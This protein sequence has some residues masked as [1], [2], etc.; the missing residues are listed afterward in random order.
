MSVQVSQLR[1]VTL[2][3]LAMLLMFISVEINGQSLEWVKQFEA[4]QSFCTDMIVDN[5]LNV[6]TSG[7]FADSI[8]LN[9]GPAKAMRYAQS[10][11][12]INHTSF[13]S[14]LDAQGNFLWGLAYQTPQV[15][16][17]ISIDVDQQNNILVVGQFAD[18]IDLD[19]GPNSQWAYAKG[20]SLGTFR[21]VFIAKYDSLGNYIWGKV[22]SAP[23]TQNSHVVWADQIKVDP[24]NNIIVSGSFKDTV[25]FDP[26]LAVF[27]M[28]GN[29]ASTGLAG[30]KYLLKLDVN[31]NFVWA[32]KWQSSLA[33]NDSGY[34]GAHEIDI[35]ATGNIVMPINFLGSIDI[36]PNSA[37]NTVTSN[38]NVDFSILKISPSGS[39]IWHKEFG[40][41][42]GN[43]CWGLSLDTWGNVIIPFESYGFSLDVD[44]G[45]AI[46]LLSW[47]NATFGRIIVK[48][49]ANG[50][51]VWGFRN[52]ENN[53]F[54][55]GWREA[56]DCDTSGNFYLTTKIWEV[57]NNQWD[58]NPSAATFFVSSR[59]LDD[60]AFQKFDSA[61]NFLFGGVLGGTI[62][63][64]NYSLCTDK[65]NG[66]YLAGYFYTNCDFDP[67][68][69]S[70]ILN[71]TGIGHDGFVLKLNTC[72]INDTV[73]LSACDSLV[74]FNTTYFNDTIVSFTNSSI[75][76]CDTTH[77]YIISINQPSASNLSFTTCDSLVLNGFTYFQSGNYNQILTNALGCDSIL[78][79][80]VTIISLDTS[81]STGP[82]NS[83]IAQANNVQYQWIDCENQQIVP[84][85]TAQIFNPTTPGF[86][87]CIITQNGCTD[88]TNCYNIDFNPS[89]ILEHANNIFLYP[90]PTTGNYFIEFDRYYHNV[91]LTL[92]SI[93]GQ[94][95]WQKDFDLLHKTNLSIEE[96]SGIYFLHIQYSGITAVKKIIKF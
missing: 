1:M 41:N 61:G 96:L 93:S 23:N 8:D 85:A 26:G 62:N 40:N 37:V 50:N 74:L 90:N 4:S 10:S 42:Q 70:L 75:S 83:L 67:T 87:A 64:Y 55:Y 63:D 31:G 91:H 94:I 43:Y 78:N 22:L 68:A 92:Q 28:V 46:Q 12:L 44:P 54:G 89:Q 35:D 86:Y 51:Y 18:S 11:T 25:D 58:L 60:I 24:F 49:D 84:G 69:D 9:P 6:I 80:N 36:D 38:G 34:F 71:S 3:K 20:T 27:N 72:L 30:Y 56:I 88:T 13:L 7:Y 76:G 19:F 21:S 79:L 66:V 15:N 33:W 48:L 82:N 39:L 5:S 29:T 59:G 53:V 17:I 52:L 16:R 47:T 14:K 95:I 77:V 2:I 57:N 81:V 45:P 32:K 65:A 73:V